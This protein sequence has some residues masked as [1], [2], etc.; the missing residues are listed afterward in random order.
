LD[1]LLLHLFSVPQFFILTVQS[2]SKCLLI[3]SSYQVIDKGKYSFNGKKAF[4]TAK[5]K[6]GPGPLDTVSANVQLSAEG[7]G[8]DAC[9]LV[10]SL[11]IRPPS[12]QRR[13][14]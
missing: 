5:L 1:A 3:F 6:T 14:R 12:M 13:R 2:I 10:D 7:S 4:F 11:L 9:W 8:D